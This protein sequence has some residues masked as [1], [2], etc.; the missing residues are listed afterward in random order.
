[1]VSSPPQK[2]H[3]LMDPISILSEKT[4]DFWF[5]CVCLGNIK[6][7]YQMALFF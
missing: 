2:Y 5:L 3:I 7:L 1:M 4:F 6:L